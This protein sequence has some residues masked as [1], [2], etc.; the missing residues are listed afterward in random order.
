M[1]PTTPKNIVILGGSYGGLSTAHHLLKHTLP[2]LAEPHQVVIVSAS[3]ETMCRPACPRALISDDMFPQ[4]KL[5]VGTAA[6]FAQ[7][8]GDSFR[9]VQGSATKLDH[10]KREVVVKLQDGRSEAIGF[11]ALVIATGASTPSPLLGL[12]ATSDE[13]RA[14]WRAFREVLPAARSIVVAGGGPTGVETAGE[15]G[16]YLNGRAGYFSR[17]LED[18]KVA[19]TLVTGGKQLL[20][21][22][23]PSIAA[24]AEEYLAQ[25]GVVVVKNARV[26]RVVPEGAGVDDVGASAVVELDSGD[27]FRADLYIPTTGTRP[28]TG[29]VDASL[30]TGD[31]R[32]ET[33]PTTLRVDKAGPRIYAIGDAS[34]YARAAVYNILTAV[35]VL[36]G[37]IKRD[38]LGGSADGGN[39]NAEGEDRVFKEDMRETQ[40]VPIGKSK[41]VGAAMGYWLPSFL[42]W[43]I[44]GR[45]YWLWTT[46]RLWSGK[47]WVKES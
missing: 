7:Y 39:G 15:L 16:E 47:Q 8:P 12:N 29:F 45:D 6:M 35:P 11:E 37:N 24:Q 5:F 2:H 41:G 4:D 23:R 27:V 30:L 17:R 33:N 38:L 34:S 42:V 36:G 14:S 32:V 19:I 22:L 3:S 40:M 18:P 13:L 1:P 46:G 21:A 26:E 28:N 43:L 10:E 44:K 9:F 31:G 20:P 25:V